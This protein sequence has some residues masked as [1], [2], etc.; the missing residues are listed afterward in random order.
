[1]AQLNQAALE[2][3]LIGI[4]A[5]GVNRSLRVLSEAGA[6]DSSRLSEHYTGAGSKFYDLVTEEIGSTAKYGAENILKLL[7]PRS[8]GTQPSEGQ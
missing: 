8:P 3:A 7:S 4:I 1:M 6:V 5:D 2:Q